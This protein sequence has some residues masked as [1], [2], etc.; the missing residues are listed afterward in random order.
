[1]SMKKKIKSKLTKAIINQFFQ[2]TFVIL[3]I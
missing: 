1:M 3:N 2:S